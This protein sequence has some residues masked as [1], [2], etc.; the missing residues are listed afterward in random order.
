MTYVINNAKPK[1]LEELVQVLIEK[2][3]LYKE[4]CLKSKK[5]TKKLENTENKFII[6]TMKV[7]KDVVNIEK[8]VKPTKHQIE[9]TT[10]IRNVKKI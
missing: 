9:P 1:Q 2:P 4:L 3:N 7:M 10:P 5:I 6:N 8:K